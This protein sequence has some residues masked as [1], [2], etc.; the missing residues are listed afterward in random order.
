MFCQV[1]SKQT[2]TVRAFSDELRQMNDLKFESLSL[3]N[4]SGD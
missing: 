1:I 4:Y 2:L 3:R